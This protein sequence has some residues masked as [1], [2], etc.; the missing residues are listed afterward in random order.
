MHRSHP[1]SYA[2]SSLVPR[3]SRDLATSGPRAPTPRP[4]RRETSEEPLCAPGGTVVPGPHALK[5]DS[6]AEEPP[7]EG[8]RV[9]TEGNSCPSQ[10]LLV[11][12]WI[13]PIH[14]ITSPEIYRALARHSRYLGHLLDAVSSPFPPGR[15]RTWRRT[16]AERR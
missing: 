15:T 5:A 10:G 14:P 1:V 3:G 13:L 8:C 4:G 7:W 11:D 9:S 16:G 2:L 6:R 12:P